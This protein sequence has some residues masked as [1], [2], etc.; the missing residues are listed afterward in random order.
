MVGALSWGTLSVGAWLRESVHSRPHRTLRQTA[1]L[2]R[3]Q[4][5]TPIVFGNIVSVVADIVRDDLF[6][7]F[8]HVD[9]SFGG[10]PFFSGV[11]ESGR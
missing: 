3:N 10:L 7:V 4:R 8:P 11:F 6:V 2:G 9:T 1:S 5:L